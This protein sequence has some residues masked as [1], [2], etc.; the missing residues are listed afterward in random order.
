MA[1][2]E[3]LQKKVTVLK[4]KIRESSKKT[5][6]TNPLEVRPLRKSLKRAQ[7]QIRSLSGKKLAVIQARGKEAQPVAQPQAQAQQ[8]AE[9]PKPAPQ[10]QAAETPKPAL[11]PQ[12]TETPKPPAAEATKPPENK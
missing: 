9:K 2:V 4:D 10:P 1:K 5:D 6:K 8:P 11:Q 3:E 7:R 12:A